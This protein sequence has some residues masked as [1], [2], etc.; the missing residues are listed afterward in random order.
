MKSAAQYIRVSSDQQLHSLEFQAS[1]IADFAAAHGYRIVHSYEDRG[2]SGLR[3]KGR[4]AL[5]ALIADIVSGAAAFETVLVQDVS[6][7]G[8]FQDPDEAA[9]YEYICR[10]AGVQV[11]YCEEQFGG[12]AGRSGD[13]VKAVKRLMAADFSRELSDKVRAAQ[14]RHAR[15]GFKM[16][17]V[18]GYGLRRAVVDGDGRVKAVLE[19]GEQRLLRGDR[20]ILVA[21]P[22]HEVETVRRIFRMFLQDDL[23]LGAIAE[24]LNAEGLLGEGGRPWS[25]WTIGN[26]LENP[27]YAGTYRFGRRRRTLD[28]RRLDNARERILL[29]EGAF[30]PIVPSDWLATAAAKRNRRML[31][32]P[33]AEL[34]RRLRDHAAQTG[35]LDRSAVSA[36]PALPSLKTCTAHF[37][38][39][40]RLCA[41]LS[42]YPNIL[43]GRID[44]R[45]KQGA[46]PP[47]SAPEPPMSSTY[48]AFV[49]PARLAAGD[50]Q[51]VALAAHAAQDR[52]PEMPIIFEDATGSVVDLDLRGAPDD[53]IRALAPSI[54]EAQADAPRTRGR[55]K[56]GVTAREITLLPK[57]WAW[58]QQQP[59]G[60][61]AA[62]RHLVEQAQQANAETDARRAAQTA[63]YKVMYA[64]AGHLAGYE[65]ALRALYADDAERFETLVSP[66]PSDVRAYVQGLAAASFTSPAASASQG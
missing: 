33:K 12:L 53:V 7:W 31:F 50:L 45:R 60:A 25:S 2:A 39:W 61:S 8:R 63:T 38:P 1:Q 55:P 54:R 3:L 52:Q 47:G 66:W 27:K 23:G 57:H 64:L 10:A 4:A 5:Q 46:S 30:Q 58:L 62:L 44:R 29:V 59:G 36:S 14:H 11:C 17:G 15:A 13:L 56:L 43:P 19:C 28:G 21:G 42:L 48:T 20:I 37:G 6:R 41:R 22:Q 18:A 51:S 65:E 26:L 24:A 35:Q 32:L 40:P 49:G 9:H 16:G 34:W